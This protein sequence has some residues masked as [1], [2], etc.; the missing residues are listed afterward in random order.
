MVIQGF[1]NGKVYFSGNL[2]NVAITGVNEYVDI[3]L[4]V[5]GTDVMSHERFYPV[6]GK[7]LLA[8][9]GKLI[10]CYFESADFSMPGDVYTGNARNV[11]IYCRDKGTTAESSTTVW[12]SKIGRQPSRLNPV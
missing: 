4:N 11:R 5:A 9:F 1:D 3:D 10:D 8:D 12:Y 2:K 7:V 6:A